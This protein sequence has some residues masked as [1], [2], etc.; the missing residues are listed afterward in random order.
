MPI[1]TRPISTRPASTSGSTTARIAGASAIV[2][3]R[4]RSGT[5]VAISSPPGTGRT[6]RRTADSSGRGAAARAPA[7]AWATVPAA[8]RAIGPGAVRAIVRAAVRR[9][10]TVARVVGIARTPEAALAADSDPHSGLHSGRRRTRPAGARMPSVTRP[11]A[12]AR[13]RRACAAPPAAGRRRA[14][15]RRILAEAAVAAAA[16]VTAATVVAQVAAA[17]AVAVVA[18]AAGSAVAQVAAVAA[19]AVVAAAGTGTDRERKAMRRIV[20]CAVVSGLVI[21]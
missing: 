3:R 13:T 6:V 18:G 9:S 19:V 16:V 2:T 20:T 1:S 7:V 12:P 4:R 17:A 8:V 15:E 21:F 5:A 10:R 11:G 14:R